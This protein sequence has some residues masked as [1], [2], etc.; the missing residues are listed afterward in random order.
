MLKGLPGSGKS[1]WA[2]EQ[3]EKSNGKIKRVNKDDLRAMID[4]GKWSKENEEAILAV[5]DILITKWCSSGLSVIV[6]DTNF[7]PKHETALS[8]FAIN[9]SYDFEV[10]FFDTP[11]DVCIRRDAARATPVGKKVIL[12]MYS[13]YLRSEAKQNPCDRTLPSAI[14]CDLDGTLALLGNRDPYDASRC[15]EDGVNHILAHML[16]LLSIRDKS[17]ILLSGRE[18]KYRPQTVSW[19]NQ[20]GIDYTSLYMRATGDRRKDAIVK[21][22]IFEKSILP[23][24]YIEA[25]FD[26]RAQVCRMWHSLGLP[27]FRF[28][29]P[30]A[31]F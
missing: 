5:R 7:A 25:V 18:D 1:Y 16:Y 21:K 28:G 17:I 9:N 15:E 2:K 14:I 31:D 10:K 24:F 30:D 13:Q 20:N 12:E 6:D 4:A 26:D 23:N 8:K 22:E 29:D 3:V 27:L 19:L 11:L